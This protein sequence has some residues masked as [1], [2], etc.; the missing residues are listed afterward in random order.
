ME[1]F[2]AI[3]RILYVLIFFLAVFISLKFQMGEESQDE[4]GECCE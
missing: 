3:V 1:F 2:L 4:R